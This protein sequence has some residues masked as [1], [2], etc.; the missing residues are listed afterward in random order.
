MVF[1]VD[2]LLLDDIFHIANQQMNKVL[3]VVSWKNYHLLRL[4][5]QTMIESQYLLNF[6]DRSYETTVINF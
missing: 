3:L 4:F 1:I 2:K 5:T 6:I